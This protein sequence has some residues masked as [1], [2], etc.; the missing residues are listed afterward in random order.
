MGIEQRRQLIGQIQEARDG[1]RV[2]CC[3]TS[4]RNNAQGIISKDFLP[5]FFEHLRATPAVGKL[6]ILLFTLGGDTLAAYALG[7]FVR[8]FSNNISVL[9]PHWCHSGG[10]LFALGANEIVMTRLATL[11]A[12]DPSIAG[13]HNPQVEPAPGQKAAVPVG[14]ESVVGFRNIAREDWRLNEA[15]TAEAFRLL[16]EKVHPLLIGDLYRTREQIVRLASNLMKLHTTDD[17]KIRD[18]VNTLATALGSH[19]Y[20]IGRTEA[21]QLKLQIADD[22]PTLED[23]I[24]QLYQDFA[25]EMELG[26][27]F[28][29]GIDMQMAMQQQAAASRPG[30]PAGTVLFAQPPQAMPPVRKLLKIV[31][32]ESF[33]RS[34]VWER[35]LAIMPPIGQ[36]QVIWNYWR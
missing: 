9:I 2:I 20:L 16:A 12:I 10:T 19:D 26:V 6:D 24:W 14:V 35:E 29:P 22:N 3:F 25:E 31:M 17:A 11:S 1:S 13:P 8:H 28:E 33:T 36:M 4:D 18:I 15:G 32:I 27:P 23:L 5:R 34:D 30:L 7:R 21:R